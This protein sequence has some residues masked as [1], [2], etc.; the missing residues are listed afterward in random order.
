[1]QDIL[2]V[3][4]TQGSDIIHSIGQHIGLSLISLLI[5]ALI[6]IPLAI[7]LMNH[8][9]SAKIMLQITSILQTIPSLALLGILIPIVG[10]GTVPSIIA[11]VIYAV[12]PI[13]QNTYAGLTTIDPN[14]EEA[15][16]AFGLSRRMKLFRIELPLA[17]P[18]I[19]SGIRIAMVLIIGTATLAAL[20]GAGGLGTY[21]L[22]GIETNNNA[23][24]IIGAVLS[25]ILALVFGAG[26][27]WL[28][29]LSFK[30]AGIVLATLVVLIGGFA[31]Y[32][33]IASPETTI[34]VAGKMGSEPELLINMYKDLIEHDHPRMKVATKAN[35]G[36]TSFLFKALKSGSVDIYPEFTG[37]VLESLV[38]GEK[39][40]SHDPAKTYQVAKSALK[41]QYQMAYLKP[42]AYQ[43]GYDLAVSKSFAAKYHLRTVSD[44]VAVEGKIHA[45]FDP[46]F[47]QLKD[48]YPGLSKTYNLKFASVKT[49]EPSIRYK[50][51]ANGKVNLV[52]GYTTDP[53][54]QEYHLV[55]LKDDKNFFPPYQGAPLMTEK[56]LTAHPE[57]RPTLNKLAGK[58]TTTDM[59]KMNYRV[60][61]KHE[62]A[63]TVAREYLKNHG[64]LD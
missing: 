16:T 7:V 28:G 35:F 11:L 56:L 3:L 45:G 21:I 36:G 50:A 34:T 5:A 49:M 10:I 62:K 24:L 27:D 60:T 38:K 63:A 46:D 57:L 17:L 33:K 18:M 51:I 43:N 13:F 58:V 29:R 22:L 37:T 4:K 52:D 23:L 44:L 59:Q 55:T 9:R 20:I 6:A 14:L 15:A 30:K 41:S 53:E 1:M 64:L 31:G 25:A 8:Q 40:A 42:M 54:V 32:R 61:V 47:Y 48:G 39:S 2:H 12:M 26:I 19:I